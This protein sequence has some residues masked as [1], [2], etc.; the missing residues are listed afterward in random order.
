MTSF[1]DVFGG[2]AVAVSQPS[3]LAL[4]MSADVDLQWPIEQAS[5][6]LTLADTID[7]NASIPG[8]NIFMPDATQ[9]STGSPTAIFN[10]VG[11]NTVTIVD[12][13]GATILSLVSG[14][15][16]VVYLYDNTTAAG[17]WRTFQLGASVSVAVA[18]ALAGAGLK[19]IGLTLNERMTIVPQ[20]A[21]YGILDSDRAT[22]QQWTAGVGTFLLPSAPIVGADWFVVVKNSGS[23]N[24]TVSAAVGTI[25]GAATAVFA[26]G[27]SAWLVTDGA[28]FFTLGQGGSSGGG[29]G[30]NLITI[31]ASGA[32][33]L[34]LS[35]AQLNQIGY[36]FTGALTGTRNIIVPGTAQE[37]W[38]DNE[39]TGAFSLFVKA[40]AQTPGIE[41]LQGD[42]NIL[43][44]DG[45]NVVS[46]ETSTVTFPIVVGQG[47]TGATT[48]SGA[49]TNLGAT[50]VGNALFTA[51]STAAA[52]AAIGAAAAAI[53]ITAGAGL[54]GGGDLSANR[55]IS[56]NFKGATLQNSANQFPGLGTLVATWDTVIT[57]IGTWYAGGNPTRLTVPAGVT[58]AEIYA[59]VQWDVGTNSTDTWSCVA[60]IRK[61]GT[62]LVVANRTKIN[63]VTPNTNSMAF[64][65]TTGPI[66]V[67]PGDFFELLISGTD[68]GATVGIQLDCNPFIVQTQFMGKSLT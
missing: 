40:A 34:V 53:T 48:A 35:G 33:N 25:D 16:W 60:E 1:N 56:L 52:L 14:T 45:T 24:L 47:G 38:I 21:N 7:V 8:L 11:A 3:Y 4:P 63:N 65:I 61:N 36:R 62:T 15:A 41:V 42:R 54:T 64:P 29:S 55:T 50:A 23:G 31:D 10:N 59:T 5:S 39:T 46:A 32:G 22:V 67:T 19:A 9:G 18:A 58:V 66:A 44:C 27:A 30:F 28:N 49:R 51:V 13:T 2:G 17:L 6:D 37:Y 12:S 20:V 26:P 57:D 68:S 43:Y